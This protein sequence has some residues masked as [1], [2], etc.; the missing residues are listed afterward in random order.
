M[1]GLTCIVY[2]LS[3]FSNVPP[4]LNDIVD[5]ESPLNRIRPL[6]NVGVHDITELKTAAQGDQSGWI[7]CTTDDILGTKHD[8]YDILVE[9]PESASG[10]QWPKIT[11]SQGTRVLATQR[12]LRRYNALRKELARMDRI[13][14]QH[15]ESEE[16]PFTDDPTGDEDES[17]PMMRSVTSLS[18]DLQ[19]AAQPSVDGE[20]LITEPAS[21]TSIAY[22]SFLWWASAGE[23][24]TAEQEE[25]EQDA[26]LLEDLVT[27]TS[28]PSTPVTPTSRPRSSSFK[29]KKRF[30][31]TSLSRLVSGQDSD[32]E[33]REPPSVAEVQQKAML[34][35]A[36][37][38]R[39]TALL[40]SGMADIIDAALEEADDNDSDEPSSQLSAE[41]VARLGLDVWSEADAKFVTD[42]SW[43]WFEREM[44]WHG[45][46]VELCGVRIC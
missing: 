39:C 8:L 30:S 3:I 2:D 17:R 21:W 44:R 40:I 5:P 14:A 41:D 25:A 26:S 4:S 19:H 10:D 33:D 28:V 34:L 22:S 24:S 12:D 27:T 45:R 42:L 43:L 6:F 37:F 20:A 23:R 7:A 46:G 9:I 35:I 11:T 38:H 32:D 13:N 16:Q 36:Y 15:R 29:R 31:S 18:P 1:L